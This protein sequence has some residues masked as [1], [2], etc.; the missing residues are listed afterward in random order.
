MLPAR[1]VE[2]LDRGV[3]AIRNASGNAYVGWRLLGTDDPAV[4][5]NVYR[6]Y[7]TATP[8]KRNATPLAASTNYLDT[9][10][11]FTTDV[12]YFVRPVIN[13]VEQGDSKR[14]TLPANAPIR[15]YLNVPLQIPAGG[16]TP[17]GEAYTY[18]AND[19]SV[20]DLDGDGDYEF[21]VKWDPSNSKDNSQSGYTG[22]TCLDAY[23]LEGARLW[24]IDLGVN[25]RAGAHY[26]Q[27][28]VYDLDSDGRAEVVMRTAPGTIDGVGHNVILGTDNP[29]TDYRNTSGY[30]ITSPEYLT[31]FDGT[32]GAARVTVPYLP[33]RGSVTEW[34]D[35]YG[36]RVDRLLMAVA[37]LDGVHP[38]LVLGRG[39]FGP[40]SG[41]TARNELTAW[42]YNG[43]NLTMRWW[44]KAGSTLNPTYVGQG[45]Y[46]MVP[47]DVDGDGKD[48]IIYGAMAIDDNGAPLYSTGRGH[49]DA[50]HVSDMDPARP[51]LEVFMPQETTSIGDHRASILRDARTGQLLAA[52]SVSASD[53]AAGTYPDVGRGVAADIDPNHLGYEFWDSYSPDIYDAQGAALY[54]KPSN[55]FTNFVV[56]WDGDLSRELLD[57]TTISEWNN[58]G[59]SN[60]D[61]DPATAGTQQFALNASSNNG[62]KSTPSL[63]ADVFGDWR[64]EVIWRRTDNTALEIFTTGIVANNRLYTLMQDTQYRE[65]V[66]WQNVGYNQPPHPSFFLGVGMVAQTPPNIVL[67]KV[68]T[69]VSNLQAE[70]AVPDG[71]TVIESTNPGFNETGYANFPTTGGSLTWNLIDGGGGGASTIR[72]R[73]ALGGGVSR[74]ARLIVNG[75]S[76]GITFANTGS[77][78]TWANLPINVTL[79]PGRNNTLRI[80]STGQDAGNVDQIELV[81]RLD[82][83]KPVLASGAFDVN[84]HSLRLVFSEDVGTSLSTADFMI[85]GPGGEVVPT[86]L[87]FDLATSTAT[88]T[89][90]IVL[91][92]GVFTLAAAAASIT[93]F[94]GNSLAAPIALNFSF[95]RGDANVDG[96]VGFDDLLIVA[97]NY[98]RATGTLF[99]E[100]DFNYD[101]Q[102]DFDDLLVIAQQ[103]GATLLTSTAL[104]VRSRRRT[105]IPLPA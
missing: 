74:T 41:Y 71:G 53:I 32:T 89:L 16:T 25:I 6:A 10:V 19:T 70:A 84:A 61:L 18:N 36:N 85:S 63:T 58:P 3:V 95:L 50:L 87:G 23:T 42:D 12:T 11:S 14:F 33:N 98:G 81:T 37:Y 45:V 104:P 80:E 94:A 100:G 92:S 56:W 26:T 88:L 82:S 35:N 65:A 76:S 57:G 7:G 79:N 101:G 62:T 17:S 64:E 93:D 4:A 9:G 28:T 105:Q 83:V 22:N 5:F 31:V 66:A 2:D 52:P 67:A 47:A 60:F 40:Q 46:N 96:I 48:E 13:N 44:F 21:V 91:P 29:A 103:Y 55:M 59:R 77:F 69:A 73:Y 15:Q 39:I 38:S 1:Y 78:T 49:G 99:S 51:G 20:G 102:I 97:Q 72:I 8:V 68:T 27:F 90:P 54:P 30:N 86:A 24:R 75:V 34:G 43:S